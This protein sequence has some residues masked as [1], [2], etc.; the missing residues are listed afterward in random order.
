MNSYFRTV[1]G[2]IRVEAG[3]HCQCHEHV[4][5]QNGVS[6]R[7]NPALRMEDENKTTRELREYRQAGGRL[8]V[9]AQPVYCG[10]M[11]RALTNVSG[12]TGVHI[13]SVT[14]FHK[15]CFY[16]EDSPIRSLDADALAALF[17]TE[18]DAGMLDEYGER[19]AAK[20][21]LVKCAL[22]SCGREWGRYNALF[23]A[24]ARAAGKTGAHVLVHTQNDTHVS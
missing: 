23:Q 24:A 21:G 16:E 14:G 17:E 5:I 13:V 12:S 20:A 7:L 10:R 9:D 15:L 1:L 8:I 11:A 2:D 4:L 18:I 19:G 22:D 3:M 6:A